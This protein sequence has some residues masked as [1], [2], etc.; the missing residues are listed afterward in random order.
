MLRHSDDAWCGAPEEM[1]ESQSCTT[2]YKTPT[3]SCG[4]GGNEGKGMSE[5]L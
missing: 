1:G 2:E 3:H 5:R 4:S